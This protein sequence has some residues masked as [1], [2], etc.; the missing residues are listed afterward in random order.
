M[1][2]IF[3]FLSLFLTIFLSACVDG[4][5]ISELLFDLELAEYTVSF[6]ID[7]EQSQYGEQ[8]VEYNEAYLDKEIHFNNLHTFEHKDLQVKGYIYEIG[9]KTQREKFFEEK[10]QDSYKVDQIVFVYL[11]DYYVLEVYHST[12]SIFPGLISTYKFEYNYQYQL[13][14][15]NTK[16]LHPFITRLYNLKATLKH[17]YTDAEITL[18]HEQ[19]NTI[20]LP[21]KSI[22]SL[23][24]I[25]ANWIVIETYNA[26]DAARI[27]ENQ[28]SLIQVEQGYVGYIIKHQ[29]LV[30]RVLVDENHSEDFLD[31]YF[32]DVTYHHQ[33]IHL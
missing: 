30:F 17:Q 31:I 16:T 1:K 32:N 26:L 21:M 14:Y 13:Y 10:K 27:Y 28:A 12:N 6:G 5:I 24:S 20:N 33:V 11:V 7:V 23:E 18:D 19:F 9:D 22:K 25:D 3:M 2:K 8:L 15:T 4:V 29:Q